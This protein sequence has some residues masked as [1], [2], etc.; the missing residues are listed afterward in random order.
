MQHTSHESK[1][2]W[3]FFPSFLPYSCTIL[4]IY[5]DKPRER[6][7]NLKPAANNNNNNNN[8]ERPPLH[9]TMLWR[10]IILCDETKPHS[11]S[12]H[13]YYMYYVHSRYIMCMDWCGVYYCIYTFNQNDIRLHYKYSFLLVFV[14]LDLIRW[15]I[16][17]IYVHIQKK[18][19]FSLFDRCTFS[20]AL[21]YFFFFLP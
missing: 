7:R 11:F 17:T 18:K 2:V 15:D 21:S 4:Y 20:F 12:V 9:Q 1:V 13:F 10:R 5:T 6:Q 8:R 3:F 19:T 16:Y 14:S